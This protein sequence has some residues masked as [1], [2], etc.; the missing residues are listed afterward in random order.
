[1]ASYS[2]LWGLREPQRGFEDNIRMAKTI[3]EQLQS[4]KQ[5]Y[6]ALQLKIHE[7]GFIENFHSI[8]NINQKV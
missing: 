5:K 4:N 6:T 3:D 1:M 7:K 8:L 2:L